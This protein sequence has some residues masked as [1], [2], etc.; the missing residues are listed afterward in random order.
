MPQPFTTLS[1][2]IV[3]SSSRPSP[4]PYFSSS[5][6]T[7]PSST[8]RLRP[9]R[10]LT[11]DLLH[12]YRQ[13]RCTMSYVVFI[14]KVFNLEEFRVAARLMFEVIKFPLPCILFCMIHCFHQ[15]FEGSICR[16]MLCRPSYIFLKSHTD[17]AMDCPRMLLF[18]SR[19]LRLLLFLSQKTLPIL[20]SQNLAPDLHHLELFYRLDPAV[21]SSARRWANSACKCWPFVTRLVF[22]VLI[23]LS[24]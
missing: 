5:C 21:L 19:V 22:S 10:M 9:L 24:K 6:S 4:S 1:S 18:G 2:P 14:N 7:C 3:L 8:Q 23:Y 15:T 11:V 12:F 17:V 16:K 20:M 13:I